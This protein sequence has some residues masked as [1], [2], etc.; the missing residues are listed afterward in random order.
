M[1]GR[2]TPPLDPKEAARRA[3]LTSLDIAALRAWMAQ[4]GGYAS[5]DDA[6][7]LQA[8]HEARA[9]D[10]VMPARLQRESVRWLR[11]H[12]PDSATLATIARYPG[13]FKGPTYGKRTK[14]S[15]E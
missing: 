12:H 8:A 15:D 11:G 7:V 10:P 5:A 14:A 3:A 2:A 1:T 13:A 6:L 9:V 4:D